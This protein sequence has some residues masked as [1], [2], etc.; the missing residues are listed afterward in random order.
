MIMRR[1]FVGAIILASLLLGGP[2]AGRSLAAP[3]PDPPRTETYSVQMFQ[4]GTRN[5][6]IAV[7]PPPSYDDRRPIPDGTKVRIKVYR[8]Y[9]GG[10]TYGTRG[11]AILAGGRGEVG[12][13]EKNAR[14]K[15]WID[16]KLR[17]AVDGKK[18]YAVWLAVS[19]VV[20]GV[21]SRKTNRYLSFRYKTKD[22]RPS[23]IRY[24]T[25]DVSGVGVDDKL[26]RP[27][28]QE[29]AG[30][31]GPGGMAVQR[32]WV[33]PHAD[34]KRREGCIVRSLKKNLGK[35]LK[36]A[37]KVNQIDLAG[38]PGL[39]GNPVNPSQAHKTRFPGEGV[40]SLLPLDGS[41][42]KGKSPSLKLGFMYDYPDRWIR[43]ENPARELRMGGHFYQNATHYFMSGT[44]RL[45]LCDKKGKEEVWARGTWKVSKRK[46]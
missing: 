16:L 24:E 40:L 14:I 38:A 28:P 30:T 35:S 23:L 39:N 29:L 19:A 44:W 33:S 2:A 27:L 13:G 4:G 37:L 5:C 8:S 34:K 22:G 20:N 3:R 18:P 17:T 11:V 36:I 45:S 12:Q 25:P 43:L 10:K 42:P 1:G 15:R 32:M 21:E 9:D 31:W 26:A 7:Y 6:W 41:K 46:E